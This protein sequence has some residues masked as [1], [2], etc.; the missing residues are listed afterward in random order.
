MKKKTSSESSQVVEGIVDFLSESGKS[1]LLPSVTQDLEDLVD[2]SK[3]ANEI[4]VTSARGMSTSQ[5]EKLQKIINTYLD[6]DLPVQ[7][8][9]DSA[10]LG[11]FSV[12]VGDFFLDA[13]ITNEIQNLKRR[14]IS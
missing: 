7:N 8:Q 9:I 11:G 5:L 3:K 13:T 14:L 1:E 12:K 6:R 10:L 4:I 2:E